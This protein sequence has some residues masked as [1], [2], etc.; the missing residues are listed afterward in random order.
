MPCFCRQIMTSVSQ[1]QWCKLWSFYC[2]GT[3][4][5]M[6]IL[7]KLSFSRSYFFFY[8]I[9]VN[10]WKIPVC[11]VPI[12]LRLLNAHTN[13]FIVIRAHFSLC[14]ASNPPP[15]LSSREEYDRYTSY[16]FYNSFFYTNCLQKN[17]YWCCFQNRMLIKNCQTIN[18][19]DLGKRLAR[20][21]QFFTARFSK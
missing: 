19:C 15:A 8:D 11:T 3:V 2:T 9:P 21:A 12:Y 1:S 20:F 14:K 7:R 10:S 4:P 13:L 17:C 18:N 5:L 6:R 16:I